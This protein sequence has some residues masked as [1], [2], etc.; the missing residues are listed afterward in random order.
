[1]HYGVCRRVY[2]TA[3]YAHLAQD[4]VKESAVRVGDSIALLAGNP[5]REIDAD[6]SA[7]SARLQDI[8]A[9]DY[10]WK[11]I[12]NMDKYLIRIEDSDAVDQFMRL[13]EQYT[14][15]QGPRPVSRAL[16]NF[17]FWAGAGFSKSWDHDAPVGSKLFKL[18][19]KIIEEFVDPLVL[20]RVFGIDSFNGISAVQFRQVVYQ[21]DMYQKYPDIRPRYFDYHNISLFKSALRS[22][23]LRRYQDITELNYFDHEFSKFPWKEPT[24]SQKNIIALFGYLFEQIDGSQSQM[25]G[26]RTHFVTTNY[27]FVIE[28]ILDNVLGLDDSLFL[29]TYRGITPDR[30]MGGPNI[31]PFHQHWLAWNL[32]KLNG[33]FEIFCDGDSYVLDYS[34]RGKEETL[35]RPPVLM[36]PSREQEYNDPYFRAVFPKA[37][38][39]LRET[40]VLILVGYSLPKDDASLRFI[41]R[42]FSEE[43]E[44]GR[45]KWI[46]YIGPESNDNKRKAISSVFPEVEDMGIHIPTVCT[47]EGKFEEFAAQCMKLK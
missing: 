34:E 20:A 25:E 19:A 36:L 9:Q 47:F 29:Y 23:V 37:I 21:I 44:D 1:M 18:K 14:F 22:A 39:L 30:I 46:F 13:V 45:G 15:D 42:Q 40:R 11:M 33:G 35:T 4:S 38:R 31:K 26:I 2:T 24:A 3:R 12:D 28:T 8:V 10:S 7:R 41:L 5:G 17:T 32:L 6:V 27:D 16:T 43:P